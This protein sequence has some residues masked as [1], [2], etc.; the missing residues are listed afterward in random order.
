MVMLGYFTLLERKVLGYGQYRK[1]PN[2]AILWGLLQ[3]MLDGFKLFM[4][5]FWGEYVSGLMNLW[6]FPS[7]GLFVIMFLW[8]V[9]SGYWGVL[10]MGLLLIYII[11]LSSVVGVMFFV[12][13]YLTGGKYS[14]IGSLRSLAQAIS[15]EGILAFSLIS[16]MVVGCGSV[17][18]LSVMGLGWGLVVMV[19]LVV[20]VVMESNR[21]PVDFVEGESELVSGLATEVGGLSFSLLFLMEYGLMS[22]YSFVL[23]LIFWGS[24]SQIL[25]VMVFM[26]LFM[27][28]LCFLRLSL[29]RSRYDLNMTWGWK[30]SL[31][32]V[33]LVYGVFYVGLVL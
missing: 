6:V 30:V 14:M 8:F 19:F 5:G 24:G 7:A 12:S 16:V 15:F 28:V 4:K 20:S 32:S 17:S 10:G 27:S 23:A 31:V 11:L 26:L 13:G 3:P 18:D 29:P 1:G 9:V 22:F 33:F 25:W 2:K 21:T